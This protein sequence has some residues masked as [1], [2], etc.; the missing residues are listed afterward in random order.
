M[1]AL[2]E[3]YVGYNDITSI[4]PLS[5]LLNLRMLGLDN[6][7]ISDVSPLQNLTNLTHLSLPYNQVGDISALAGLTQLLILNLQVNQLDDISALSGMV[8]LQ[9]LYMAYNNI[10]T[11]PLLSDLTSLRVLGLDNNQINEISGLAGLT[12]LQVLN[13]QGNQVSDISALLG[14]AALQELY[15]AYNNITSIS[16]LSGLLNLRILGLDNNQIGDVTPLQNL[17]NLTHLSL[18]YNQLGDISA[19][20]GLTQLLMLNLQGNHLSGISALSGAVALQELYLAYNNIMD[21]SP[22]SGLFSLRI[23]GLD[24]NQITNIEPLVNNLGLSEGDLVNLMNNPLDADSVTIHIPE[25]KARGVIVWFNSAPVAMDDTYS[26]D[27]D[28]VLVI[29]APGVLSNDTDLDGDTLAAGIVTWPVHGNL[30]LNGDGSF[31][32]TPWGVDYN[33]TDT[34]TYATYDGTAWSNIATVT[35]TV[36]PVN[37]APVAVDDGYNATEDTTLSI[38][39]PG[40]LA[41]D[42]DIDSATLTAVKVTDPTHGTLTLNGDGSF[43]YTPN[44]DWYGSDSFTY[45]ANDGALDS[46]IATV[47]VTVNPVPPTI[48]DVSPN[49][50]TQGKT[51]SVTITGTNFIGATSVNFGS[52][53]TVTSFIVKNSAKIT[54]KI[55]ISVTAAPGSRDVCVTTPRGAA[56]MVNGFTVLQGPPTV[57]GVVPN[58]GIRGQTLN[59]TISGTNFMGATSVNF[60]AGILVNS[61]TVVGPGEIVANITV[62]ATTKTGWRNV[63][64]TTKQ[65]TGTLKYGFTVMG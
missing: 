58:Q 37:D 21:I 31:S 19:L 18:L 29:P 33:G 8:A 22:L 2:Q 55:S 35:I 1:V 11:I 14:M 24:N 62:S 56:T 6:N 41:N 38:A 52:G 34:F 43:S 15:M 45:K 30:I 36:N 4:S 26:V 49:Q 53:I 42:T 60:G 12:Q 64:V 20:A 59:V 7:Q 50:G 28:A 40:F 23:L 39:A 63:S 25:L 16:P 57:T 27:E 44:A 17:T 9:E 3:L 51:L 46:N 65:G 13:L 32:Y 54:A 47:T 10:T 48:I 61:F 5:G